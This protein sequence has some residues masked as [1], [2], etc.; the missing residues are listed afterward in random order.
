MIDLIA[1]TGLL[2]VG[3]V[4]MAMWQSSLPQAERRYV[5]WSFGAHVVS[6]VAMV[7]VTR[8]F[9]K[10]GD[11]LAYQREGA[12][13]AEVLGQNFAERGYDFFLYV[14]GQRPE[15]NGP[16]LFA[17]TSTGAMMGVST[18]LHLPLM[19]SIY[20]KC[21]CIAM[22]G[23]PSKYYIYRGFSA[24]FHRIY[25]QRIL[26]GC[27]LLPSTVFWT[28]GMLK[29]PMAMLGMGPLV[30][31]S[32]CI[33]TKKSR[34]KG[35]ILVCIGGFIVSIFKAYILFPWIIAAA[36]GYYWQRQ[37]HDSGGK[38]ALLTRPLYLIIL[39][40]LSVG[41][42]IA[43]G[44][45]F[46]RYSIN[47]ITDEITKLQT[48]GQRTSG[49]SN[50]T[51]TTTEPKSQSAVISLLP[52]G[53]FFSLFRPFLFEVRNA[54]LLINALETTAFI[55][56]W[57]RIF[58]IHG[59]RKLGMLLLRTPGLICAFAFVVLFGAIVGIA[60]TNVGTL[61]RYRIPMM[62]FYVSV[63]L[64]LSYRPKQTAKA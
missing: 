47:D 11:L 20:A 18:W 31:G 23:V 37:T 27:M 62:P 35:L 4:I 57:A 5:W 2:V 32:M 52:M 58:T 8:Y 45:L 40:G 28:S 55:I 26:I 16:L 46:P 33:I 22:L 54:A 51:I 56:L 60:T 53:L 36:L 14:I 50:Y 7:L 44:T 59:V 61:S 64:I 1:F 13:Y 10:G 24:F 49:G 38:S 12:V 42:L 19:G 29:E 21:L 3:L 43:L 17:G 41:G 63:L 15:T 9:F 48:I 30:Y 6:A 39:F 25:H 34:I